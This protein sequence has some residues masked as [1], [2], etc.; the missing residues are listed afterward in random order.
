[1][2]SGLATLFYFVDVRELGATWG[3]MLA[4][5]A[6]LECAFDFCLGCVFLGWCIDMSLVHQSVNNIHLNVLDE[7]RAAW[8]DNNLLNSHY[9]VPEKKRVSA[10]TK[11]GTNPADITYKVPVLF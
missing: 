11:G 9:S 7:R 1:M 3:A 4:F 8:D 10:S 5:A 6:G 2:F